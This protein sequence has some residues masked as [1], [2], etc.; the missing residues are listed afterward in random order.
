MYRGIVLVFD[1]DSVCLSV[2]LVFGLCER[3][4]ALYPFQ[5]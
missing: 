4:S 1:S 3:K 2:C 5:T